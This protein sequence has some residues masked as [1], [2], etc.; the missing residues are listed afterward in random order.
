MGQSC[1]QNGLVLPVACSSQPPE[2]N[3]D[4]V[5]ATPKKGT[6]IIPFQT[7]F[8]FWPQ[9]AE[10]WSTQSKINLFDFMKI[11]LF[12]LSNDGRNSTVPN[13]GFRLN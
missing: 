8:F 7:F 12:V 11:I 1:F 9:A 2:T 3:R 4:I 13:P 6:A 10:T 5:L